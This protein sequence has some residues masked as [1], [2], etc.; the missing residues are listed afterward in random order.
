[1]C[2]FFWDFPRVFLSS[3][4][5]IYALFNDKKQKRSNVKGIKEGGL[6]GWLAGF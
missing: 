6:V 5:Y 2:P 4:I 3:L 1:M